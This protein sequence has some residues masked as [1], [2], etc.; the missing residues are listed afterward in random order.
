MTTNLTSLACLK[1]GRVIILLFAAAQTFCLSPKTIY[2]QSRSAQGWP[3]S[4][5]QR[6]QQKVEFT[7][8][9]ETPLE[10]LITVAKTFDIPM[11]VEWN[12]PTKCQR[13]MSRSTAKA[14][15]LQLLIGIVGR[16]PDQSLE[17]GNG[18]V[19]IRSRRFL[20]R[21]NIL[22]LRLRRF[23]VR[24]VSLFTAEHDLRIAI[25]EKLHPQEYANGYNGG[26]GYGPGDV[27]AIPNVTFSGAN[28]SVRE[29]LDGIARS[30][31][32]AIWIVRLNEATL[33]SET[34]LARAYSNWEAVVLIWHFVPIKE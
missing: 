2:A 9:A 19:H 25:D 5:Q 16:C 30:N 11:G 24:N 3:A 21:L 23:Q 28:V 29:V 8:T 18:M 7:P 33:K 27:F 20:S 12:E 1:P 26:Y 34:S 14:T 15:V 32:N 31:G 22:N 10:E 4:F 13:S 17:V 6:L